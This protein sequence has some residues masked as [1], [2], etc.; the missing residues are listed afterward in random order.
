MQVHV[1]AFDGNVNAVN[2]ALL[3][4]VNAYPTSPYADALE[5]NTGRLLS[6][7][8]G[9]QEDVDAARSKTSRYIAATSTASLAFGSF[10]AALSVLSFFFTMGNYR[11]MFNFLIPAGVLVLFSCWIIFGALSSA[12]LLADDLCQAID[13]YADASCDT[14][15]APSSYLQAALPCPSL[16]QR[17]ELLSAMRGWNADAADYANTLLDNRASDKKRLCVN[18]CAAEVPCATSTLERLLPSGVACGD[19]VLDLSQENVTQVRHGV[20]PK[21]RGWPH[22]TTANAF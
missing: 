12:N 2:A 22:L 18:F 6:A 17:T 11:S 15:A 21:L 13:Q 3:A 8:E 16:A 7:L 9:G 5:T 19:G 4:A 20:K 1:D 10:V 14:C